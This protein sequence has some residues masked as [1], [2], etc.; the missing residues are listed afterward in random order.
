MLLLKRK[1]EYVVWCKLMAVQHQQ[2]AIAL[3]CCNQ[4]REKAREYKKVVQYASTQ[5]IF[6]MV[7]N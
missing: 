4:K 3:A 2:I 6:H 1:R 7:R 5:Q